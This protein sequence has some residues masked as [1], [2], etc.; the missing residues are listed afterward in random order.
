MNLYDSGDLNFDVNYKNNSI[1][2]G[3]V[4]NRLEGH[5]D[6][7]ETS[8]MGG[9]EVKDLPAHANSI[10]AGQYPTSIAT[11]NTGYLG[12]Q[13][14]ALLQMLSLDEPGTDCGTKNPIPIAITKH[15]KL[16][17][18]DSYIHENGT[19]VLLTSQNIDKYVGKIVMMRSPM[20]CVTEKIC[21]ICAGELFYKLD[22]RDAGMY[23]T[24]L[25]HSMLNL[26]LKAKHVSTISLTQLDVNRIIEDV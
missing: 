17:M 8:H 18:L 24:Q 25:S 6:F 9:L 15:N 7:I 5:F 14:I 4:L 20:S 12:K 16:D 22:I 1:I 23:S 2:K 21:N 19:L 11:A 26:S 3:P 10:I 13:L